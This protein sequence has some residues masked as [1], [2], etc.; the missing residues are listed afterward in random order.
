LVFLSCIV[1]SASCLF[2]HRTAAYRFSQL[3]E[4]S[5]RTCRCARPLQPLLWLVSDV[6]AA[7]RAR[8]SCS[9]KLSK[10]RAQTELRRGNS[11]SIRGSTERIKPSFRLLAPRAMRPFTEKMYHFEQPLCGSRHSAL[12]E[13]WEVSC[14]STSDQSLAKLPR[15]RPT[16][17][18]NLRRA[19]TK[20]LPAQRVCCNG[21]TDFY[22]VPRH[23]RCLYLSMTDCL[24][25]FVLPGF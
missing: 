4:C 10:Q 20:A 21:T 14:G 15:P 23:R 25:R 8:A 17:S 22:T 11:V 3:V 5:Y 6:R 19:S 7:S 9:L 18:T 12:R 1:P 16:L 2:N 24:G 13:T